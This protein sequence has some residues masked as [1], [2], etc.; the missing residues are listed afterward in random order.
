MEQREQNRAADDRLDAQIERLLAGKPRLNEPLS[1]G[2]RVAREFARLAAEEAPRLSQAARSQGLEALHRRASAE[3]ARARPNFFAWLGRVPH[4]AQLAAVALIVVVIANGVSSAAADSLPGSPLYP[5]K[6]LNEGGQLLL[7]NSNAQRAQMWMNLANKRL[8][9]V[10]RLLLEGSSVDPSALD[11]VD[12]SILQSLTEIARTRGR[13]RVELLKQLTQ[14][15]IRQQLLVDQMAQSADE[16]ARQ[17][18]IQT[19]RLLGNVASFAQSDAAS[20]TEFDPRELFAPSAA[21]SASPTPAATRRDT[22]TATG[23]ATR[24]LGASETGGSPEGATPTS[25]SAPASSSPNEEPTA[26]PRSEPPVNPTPTARQGTATSRPTSEPR[27]TGNPPAS[28]KPTE[29]GEL[30]ETRAATPRPE[31]TETREPTRPPEPGET[32][33]PTDQP[34]PTETH[35]PTH[36]PEPS[37]TRKPTDQPEPTETRE[38]TELPEPTHTHE[39]SPTRE[40]TE[41][42]EPNETH[43]PTEAPEPNKTP[44]PSKTPEP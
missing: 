23:Q 44:K 29:K 42:R 12:E 39:P 40:P 41:T 24:T 13:E 22:W 18:F 16:Q 19:A 25:Q 8:D 15:A 43:E 3:R 14:L 36:V 26:T 7:S 9:E 21:P 33:E 5:F 31:R 35:E 30:T 38:P 37:E 2:E 32:R 11:A 17:R 4:W 27:A 6:R 10:Q 20:S 28:P 1:G 34:E